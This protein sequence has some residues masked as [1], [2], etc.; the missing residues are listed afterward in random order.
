[1]L[2]EPLVALVILGLA[3]VGFLGAFQGTARATGNAQEW[4]EAVS[5]AEAAMEA[6]K[7]GAP[8]TSDARVV[9]VPWTGARGVREIRVIV[10]LPAGGE[11]VLH[12]LERAR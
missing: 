3:A 6:T 11:F 9:I 7:L 10:Q 1:M 8:I 12:R 5:R 2:L 4:V